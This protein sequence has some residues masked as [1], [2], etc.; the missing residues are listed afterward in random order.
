MEYKNMHGIIKVQ[1]DIL[2]FCASF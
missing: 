1:N 2:L